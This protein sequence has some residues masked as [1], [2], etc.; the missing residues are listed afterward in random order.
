MKLEKQ[1]KASN[2]N[3]P[4]IYLNRSMIRSEIWNISDIQRD[5]KRL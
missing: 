5:S 1:T 4:Q 3:M 2:D